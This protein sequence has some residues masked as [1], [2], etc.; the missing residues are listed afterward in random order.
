MR[1]VDAI[2]RQVVEH[3]VVTGKIDVGYIAISP[4][5]HQHVMNE[6]LGS[7]EPVGE[8]RLGDVPLVPDENV[9]TWEIRPWESS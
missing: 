7:K 3:Q 5:T 4:R 1:L 2:Y 6:A 9:V 8:V